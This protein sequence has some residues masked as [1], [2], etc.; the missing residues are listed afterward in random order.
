MAKSQNDSDVSVKVSKT[1]PM[2]TDDSESTIHKGK[3]VSTA[4]S[5]NITKPRRGRPPGSKNT[6]T[7]L[8]EAMENR[9][10]EEVEKE[11]EKVVEST[12]RLA[13]KGDSTCLKILWDRIV[14][15]RKAAGDIKGRGDGG[16]VINITGTH[17]DPAIKN[18][19]DIQKEEEIDGQETASTED[20]V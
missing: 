4:G 17:D 16:I 2:S 19:I 13:K 12:I 8:Q 15:S 9:T 6:K 11:W 18:I 7:I 5:R 1:S 14:P 3:E 20:S 10:F